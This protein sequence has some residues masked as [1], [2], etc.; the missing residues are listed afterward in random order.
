MDRNDQTKRNF[1]KKSRNKFSIWQLNIYPGNQ[2]IYSRRLTLKLEMTE[3]ELN[4]KKQSWEVEKI[5]ME[6]RLN[7]LEREKIVRETKEHDM[8][9]KYKKI[10]DENEDLKKN[11]EKLLHTSKENDEDSKIEEYK[12]K[13]QKNG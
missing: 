4:E 2:R 13:N 7:D 10:K 1:P 3:N 9:E 11:F 5:S 12:K 8:H 6:K